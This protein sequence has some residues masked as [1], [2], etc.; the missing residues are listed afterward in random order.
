M[1]RVAIQI[2]GVVE[3]YDADGRLVKAD[4]IQSA[5]LAGLSAAAVR[6]ACAGLG[7]QLAAAFDAGVATPP[8][9]GVKE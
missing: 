5:M 4:Q 2:T 7:E 9:G 3:H 8:N 6:E 1:T